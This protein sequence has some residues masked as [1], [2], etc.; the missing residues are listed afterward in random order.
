MKYIVVLIL[1]LSGCAWAQWAPVDRIGGASPARLEPQPGENNLVRAD[2]GFATVYD[3]NPYLRN[4]TSD[5]QWLLELTPHATWSL[6]RKSWTWIGDYSAD[7]VRGVDTDLY[8]RTN[9]LFSTKLAVRASRRLSFTFRN[10][11]LRGTDAFLPGLGSA[12]A[13][14]F[15]VTQQVNTAFIG[16]VNQR[17]SE[18]VGADAV[19]RLTA[20][21]RAGIGGTFAIMRYEDLRGIRRPQSD[22][23]LAGG[24]GFLDH[25]FSARRTL[26][27][28]YD[29][30]KLTSP[31]G[32][33]TLVHRPSVYHTFSINDSKTFTLFAGPEHTSMTVPLGN[34][35]VELPGEW[36]WSAGGTFNWSG[37]RTGLALNLVR[38]TNDGAGLVGP[39]QMISAG[40]TATRRVGRRFRTQ[41]YGQ[42]SKND[43][44]Q[45]TFAGQAAKYGSGGASLS[46]DV[47]R[48]VV[49]SIAYA[50][51][52]RLYLLNTRDWTDQ[53]RFTITLRY[54]L[55]H[56]LGVH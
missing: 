11:F 37:S 18:Q 13:R 26:G 16:D 43:S 46:W 7:V 53:N 29:F 47:T 2:A 1:L 34:T 38:E 48:S 24:N 50:R 41:F 35:S 10:S 4:T 54:T 21:T 36:G 40:F 5:G 33:D 31:A 55:S 56:P 19:Y 20:H 17:T 45:H 28:S 8:D 12:F 52:T 25:Q 49:A 23:N 15:D 6:A 22:T 39:V 32:W 44:V 27:V 14:G 51:Q 30:R 3:D 42:F 9:H